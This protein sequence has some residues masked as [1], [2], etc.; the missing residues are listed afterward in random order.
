VDW[1]KNLALEKILRVADVKTTEK[2]P[3]MY[4]VRRGSAGNRTL[5]AIDYINNYVRDLTVVIV[6]S[7]KFS[8]I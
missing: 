5:G 1:D 7:E 2:F 3:N 4:F 6:G 8:L